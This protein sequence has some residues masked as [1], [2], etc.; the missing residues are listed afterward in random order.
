MTNMGI[1]DI[2]FHVNAKYFVN[3]LIRII[4]IDIVG[5]MNCVGNK[6]H[7]LQLL[8]V[9]RLSCCKGKPIQRNL[10]AQYNILRKIPGYFV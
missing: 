6:L 4:T 5:K 2:L 10:P 9:N 3:L 8:K 1:R 7:G